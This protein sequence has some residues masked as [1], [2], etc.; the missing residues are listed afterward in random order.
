LK[1]KNKALS[2]ALNSTVAVL[3]LRSSLF[4][5]F[6]LKKDYQKLKDRLTCGTA[7]LRNMIWPVRGF[8]GS[9]NRFPT[10]KP[11]LCYVERYS[12]EK[13]WGRLAGN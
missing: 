5:R 12:G 9:I 13:D 3:F 11:N 6:L 4:I 7:S 2:F 1:A 10:I 8:R